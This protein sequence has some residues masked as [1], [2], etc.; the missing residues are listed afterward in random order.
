MVWLAWREWATQ[1]RQTTRLLTRAIARRTHSQL[2]LTLHAWFH[3][4]SATTSKAA[5]LAPVRAALATVRSLCTFRAWRAAA[6]LSVK[7]KRALRK[8]LA[9][10]ERLELGWWWEDWVEGAWVA[11]GERVREYAAVTHCLRSLTARA[12][13]V[14]LPLMLC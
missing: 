5:A 12:F 10:A 7:Q 3:L 1:R 8:V 4:R 6:A 2:H 9:T 13:E 11:K 14:W